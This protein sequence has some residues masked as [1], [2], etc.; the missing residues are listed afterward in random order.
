[1]EHFGTRSVAESSIAGALRA[2][3]R[4]PMRNSLFPGSPRCAVERPACL[5]GAAGYP[6]H[7]WSVAAPVGMLAPR[8]AAKFAGAPEECHELPER[9]EDLDRRGAPAERPEHRGAIG[10]IRITQP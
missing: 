6:E 7:L 3:I 1:M 9:S 10:A 2:D 4:A 5:R 8:R